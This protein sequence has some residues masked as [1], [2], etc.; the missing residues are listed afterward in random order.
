METKEKQSLTIKDV[1]LEKNYKRCGN[2]KFSVNSN[3]PQETA[4]ELQKDLEY[5]P[6]GYG[7]YAFKN[8][9]NKTTWECSN[10]CD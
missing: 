10:S 7:F 5:H 1:T 4:I 3:I 2:H 9:G 8:D 6:G